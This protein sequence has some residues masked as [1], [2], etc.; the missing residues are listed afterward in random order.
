MNDLKKLT[1]KDEL[2]TWIMPVLVRDS[3]KGW[4]T[5]DLTEALD[6]AKEQTSELNPTSESFKMWLMRQLAYTDELN[7]RS[8]VN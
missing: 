6:R 1:Y 7:R 3:L 5:E 4:T 8:E 2:G